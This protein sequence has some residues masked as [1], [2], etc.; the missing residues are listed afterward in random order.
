MSDI[1]KWRTWFSDRAHPSALRAIHH[2]Q[3]HSL[4]ETW[5][6]GQRWDDL[7]V[8]T[9]PTA[10]E[11]SSQQFN[12]ISQQQH[13]YTWHSMLWWNEL[14]DKNC[15]VTDKHRHSDKMSETDSCTYG[16]NMIFTQITQDTNHQVWVLCLTQVRQIKKRFSQLISNCYANQK[17][18]ITTK[19]TK[20]ISTQKPS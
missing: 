2:W 19:A 3:H 10:T 15:T 18:S 7:T 5:A 12:I 11:H 14:H 13:W 1:S 4:A 6:D 8:W 20:L 9:T 17:N 16:L